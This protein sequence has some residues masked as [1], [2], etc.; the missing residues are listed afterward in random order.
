MGGGSSET[1]AMPA[2]AETVERQT[3]GV[4]TQAVERKA[5]TADDGVAG[6]ALAEA[7]ATLATAKEKRRLFGK[8]QS[9]VSRK[10][11]KHFLDIQK[12]R[13]MRSNL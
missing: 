5:A 7:K 13:M 3:E 11:P 12:W 2:A 9:S 8:L 4:E 10:R 1:P 6:A